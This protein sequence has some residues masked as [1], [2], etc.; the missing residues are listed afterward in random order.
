[1]GGASSLLVAVTVLASIMDGAPLP[2]QQQASASNV[3]PELRTDL[4]V[5]HTAAIELAGGAVF[6]VGE[7]L[8]LGGDLGGGVAGGPDHGASATGR[9]DFYGRFH[10]DPF[11]QS[12]W[13]IYLVGGGSYRFTAGERSQLYLLVAVGAEGP[14]TG[15]VVP[16]FEAG[17]A[18]GFRLG[19]ALRRGLKNRR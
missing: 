9:A 8:R 10:L 7:Y 17:F 11:A 4:I 12:R 1:M 6:P 18:G 16:A 13:A 3:Q 5:A 19:F 14:T 15:G 2:A